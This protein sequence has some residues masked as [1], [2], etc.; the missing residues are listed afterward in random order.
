[1]FLVNLD[2]Q[3]ER[4][5]QVMPLRGESFLAAALLVM[6]SRAITQILVTQAIVV[7]QGSLSTVMRV[8]APHQLLAQAYGHQAT[9]YCQAEMNSS[10]PRSASTSPSRPRRNASP[11]QV[12]AKKQ[13]LEP[14]Q[15]LARVQELESFKKVEEKEKKAQELTKKKE[16]MAAKKK[17]TKEI[18]SATKEVRKHEKE[19]NKLS[20]QLK[21][22]HT[23][24]MEAEAKK[25]RATGKIDEQNQRYEKKKK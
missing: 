10:G 22:L 18:Q 21:K 3:P 17:L 6:E 8:L 16:L 5:L 4:G 14:E 24:E 15:L 23:Q 9:G 11:R 20:S 2:T 25:Q 13:Q 12:L 1:M 19:S 7:P